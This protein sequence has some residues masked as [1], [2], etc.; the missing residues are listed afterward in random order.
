MRYV[1]AE[2]IQ[3]IILSK[4][5]RDRLFGLTL[6]EIIKKYDLPVTHR[7]LERVMDAEKIT[8]SLADKL[9]TRFLLHARILWGDEWDR[10]HRACTKGHDVDPANSYEDGRCR[11]C[12]IERSRITRLRRQELRAKAS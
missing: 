4:W 8:V 10:V 9:A 5:N 6:N 2:P 3:K 12:S 11:I 1:S 7:T